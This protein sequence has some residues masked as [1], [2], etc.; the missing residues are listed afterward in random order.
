MKNKTRIFIRKYLPGKLRDAYQVYL[1]GKICEC[2][3]DDIFLYDTGSIGQLHVESFSQYAQDAFIY[4]MVFG[5]GQGE[6]PKEGFFLDIGGNDPIKI[7]NTYLFEQ[8]G[9]TGLAFEPV[10]AQA[11]KWAG[12]RKT[13]CYNI[14]LGMTESEV[15]FTEMSEHEFSGIGVAE[16]FASDFAETVTYKVKQRML[17]NVL[18][19]NHI[20]HVDVVSIDVEGY[21][22]NVLR[23]IDFEEVD[24]TCFCIENNRDGAILPNMDLRKF[25]L[26][27]GYRLIARLSIDDIFVK[28]SYFNKH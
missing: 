9:W 21:E 24:I 15:E 8:K 4:Q 14:A 17:S 6:T 25:M 5:G 18:R 10:K 27:K 20:K 11:D 23:G 12:V 2:A 3:K 19:E 13:P 16:R 1:R 7:N 28:E 22:M 26:Q